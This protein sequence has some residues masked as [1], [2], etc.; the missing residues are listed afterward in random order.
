MARWRPFGKSQPGS[1]RI[2]VLQGLIHG[3]LIHLDRLAPYVEVLLAD[4]PARGKLLAP[5]EI[6]PRQ[7]QGC[8]SAIQRR[9]RGAEIGNL[10]IDVLDGVLEL[11]AVGPRL[12]YLT[13]HLGLGGHQVRFGHGDSSSLDSDLNLE[14]FLVKLDQQ[15]S[16]FHPV[17]VIHQ[18][19]HHLSRHPG[20]NEGYVAIDIGVIGTHRLQRRDYRRHQVVSP[21]H[22]ADRD[23]REEEPFSPRVRRRLSRGGCLRCGQ[24]GTRRHLGRM[25]VRWDGLL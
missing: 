25:L 17:V 2:D 18:H 10:V 9:H 23:R 1:D 16:F 8:P 6:G 24:L 21:N 5:F 14:G 7:F 15:V 11:E 19:A 13:A 12:G 22:Q 20:S 3:R 4:T